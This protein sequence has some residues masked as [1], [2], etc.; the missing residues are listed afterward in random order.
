VAE[1]TLHRTEHYASPLR[2]GGQH[3]TRLVVCAVVVQMCVCVGPAALAKTFIICKGPLGA[4]P[5]DISIQDSKFLGRTIDCISGNFVSDMTPCAPPNGFGLSAPTGSADLVELVNRWQ[6]YI[7]HSG[8]VTGHYVTSDKIYFSGGFNSP[9]SG[10][11]EDWSFSINRLTGSAELKQDGKPSI[12]YT[13]SK[14]TVC[15]H[16]PASRRSPPEAA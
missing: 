12:A 5:V 1:Q 7:N 10:Y 14:A 15:P 9:D 6:D 2:K 8:G 3:L 13:C 16:S 4:Q 11:K